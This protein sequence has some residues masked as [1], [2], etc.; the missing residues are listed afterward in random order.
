MNFI[1]ENC[2]DDVMKFWCAEA[3]RQVC[4]ER[5]LSTSQNLEDLGKGVSGL[6]HLTYIWKGEGREAGEDSGH[7]AVNVY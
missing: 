5:P 7:A 3:L 6:F 4:L 1:D 2:M